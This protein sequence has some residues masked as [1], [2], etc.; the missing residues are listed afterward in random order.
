MPP[1]GESEGEHMRTR[2]SRRGMIGVVVGALGAA[3][4]LDR[5][6]ASEPT[7]A[8]ACYWYLKRSFCYGGEKQERWCYRCCDTTGCED[9]YCEWRRVGPC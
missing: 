6:Q 5:V 1:K 3:V 4:G 8:A 2:K 7:S 9:A